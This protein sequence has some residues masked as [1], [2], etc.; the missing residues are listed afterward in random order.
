MRRI[1]STSDSLSHGGG[2]RGAAGAPA[3]ATAGGHAPKGD[4][5][6]VGGGGG[7]RGGAGGGGTAGGS[8]NSIGSTRSPGGT[9]VRVP[10][11]AGPARRAAVPGASSCASRRGKSNVGGSN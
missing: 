2:A 6:D 5:L 10:L 1:C 8:T 11:P 9:A 3:P 4:P 7:A